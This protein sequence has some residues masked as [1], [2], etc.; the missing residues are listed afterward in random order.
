ME[1]KTKLQL[2]ATETTECHSNKVVYVCG[3]MCVRVF[4]CM[5]VRY[6]RYVSNLDM[7]ISFVCIRCGDRVIKTKVLT[8]LKPDIGEISDLVINTLVI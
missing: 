3:Y 8:F 2:K 7:Q 6:M 4:V 5:Y 1:W